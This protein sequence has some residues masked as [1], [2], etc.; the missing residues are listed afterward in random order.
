M[1][2][3]SIESFID[4]DLKREIISTIEDV[5]THQKRCAT[6]KDIVKMIGISRW[7]PETITRATR[8]LVEMGI[9]KRWKPL[10]MQRKATFYVVTIR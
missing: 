5:N 9:V 3:T 1:L 2:N 4:Y 6:Y 7:S 10:K 8:L